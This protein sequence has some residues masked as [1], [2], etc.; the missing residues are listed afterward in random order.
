MGRGLGVTAN[1][2]LEQR[3]SA[4]SEPTIRSQVVISPLNRP[5]GSAR[6][7]L[8]T[9]GK[10]LYNELATYYAFVR[11]TVI[12]MTAVYFQFLAVYSNRNSLEAWQ[13]PKSG[14]FNSGNTKY[15]KLPDIRSF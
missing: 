14:T 15:Q 2:Y 10:R 7:S 12:S 1:S 4:L 8:I 6:R 13:V 11:F 5:V 3:G 9:R